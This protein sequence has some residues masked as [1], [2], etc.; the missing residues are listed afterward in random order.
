MITTKNVSWGFYGTL[1]SN[2]ANDAARIFDAAARALV[3]KLG[4]TP[5]EARDILDAKVGRHMADQRLAGE[6]WRDLVERLLARMGWAHDMR[7]ALG[8]A[9]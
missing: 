7:A 6:S 1:V 3:P 4:V 8:A 2:G 5:D 9:R